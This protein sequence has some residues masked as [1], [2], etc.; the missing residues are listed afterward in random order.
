MRFRHAAAVA[1]LAAA[2]TGPL[3]GAKSPEQESPAT[4]PPA[5][6]DW[7][8]RRP[9][10]AVFLA[11]SG[12]NWAKNP[13]G[14]FNDANLDIR[15]DEGRLELRRRLFKLAA[16][17]VARVQD[18][19][20]Q[21]IIVWDIEGGEMPHAVTYLGDPRALPDVAPEMDAVADEFFGIFLAAGLRTGVCIRPTEIVFRDPGN[22]A[23]YP[24]IKGRYGHC[25]NDDPVGVLAD[26]IAYA[27]RR[28]G[29]TI[30]Y[31]DTN[32][33]PR[34]TPDGALVRKTSGGP[35]VFRMISPEEIAELRRRHPD[36][37]V[38]P[39]FQEPGCF[40][41][42]SGYGEYHSVG[43]F[44][45][46]AR[47]VNPRA[48]RVWM[49]R[50][51]TDDICAQWD[52]FVEKGVLTGEVFLFEGMGAMGSLLKNARSEKDLRLD[53]AGFAPAATATELLA[54]LRAETDWAKRRR[55]VDALAAFPAEAATAALR[56]VALGSRDGLELFAGRALGRQGTPA[57]LAA[58]AAGLKTGGRG[59]SASAAGL[60]A[61]GQDAALPVLPAALK[62]EKNH[63]VRW[64]AIDAL[65]ELART[66]AVPALLAQLESLRGTPAQR[67]KQKT[68]DALGK[69]GDAR[70]LGPLKAALASGDFGAQ[71][72]GLR[73]AIAAI[74]NKQP[75]QE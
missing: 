52:A 4:P 16:D 44:A 46:K 57:A 15:T 56:K 23:R 65:G 7:A 22:P 25:D 58:L 55:I 24:W 53:P 30:F 11:A 72:S 34:R 39:E 31:M 61:S 42:A 41:N 43:D 12:M 75:P 50:L 36:V 2:M 45:A 71:A 21:G 10:S 49:P 13:R 38:W 66:D 68:I 17:T 47:A 5:P 35:P 54:Q 64:A 8:D 19:G 51:G 26:K 37:L 74:E 40:L 60:G 62:A 70:A 29:C 14:Y 32:Y 73:R 9:I 3:R 67:S 20:G 27:K 1:S 6:F 48:F 33:T 59:A 28:W 69:I 18:V 63:E